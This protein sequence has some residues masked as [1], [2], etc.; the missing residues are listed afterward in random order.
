MQDLL[1]L[2]FMRKEKAGQE[3]QQAATAAV[4][5][6]PTDDEL[7]LRLYRLIIDRYRDKIEEYETKSVSDIKGLIQPRHEKITEI[8]DSI[9][10][11]FHPYVYEQHFLSA[12]KMA[13]SAVSSFRTI[14]APVSFWLSFSDIQEIGAGDEIDKSIL[15]CSI[16]RSLGSENAKVF[17]T[18]T[19]N[20]YSLFQFD[21]KSY[22]AD[23]SQKELLEFADGQSALS[24]LKGKLLYAF[25]DKDYE[26]F[27]EAEGAF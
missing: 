18:D 23:H 1:K 2:P 9:T 5:S 4:P 27:Q 21:G 22:A 25:N 16:F 10:Q 3:S 20:S 11:D 7:K 6:E 24:S 13:F 15:L 26:D 8:R 14:A 17:V 19:R 12:A